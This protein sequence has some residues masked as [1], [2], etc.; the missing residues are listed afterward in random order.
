M[1]AAYDE[2]DVPVRGGFLHV[3]RW[4]TEPDLPTVVAVHGV[5]ANHRCWIALA[6]TGAVN[7]VAPDLRGRGR[8]G[9]LP[10]PA[11][12]AAHAEDLLTVLEHVGLERALLVGHS[13]G[14][15]VVTA[16]AAAHPDRTAGVLLVDGGLPL[17]APPPGVT[18]EQALAATIGP[19]AARLEMTFAD[20]AAY[21]D[22]WRPHPALRD[23][24]SADVEDYLGYDLV[25]E[26][27]HCRSSV[28]LEAV[29]DDSADLL[30][31]EANARRA[32][33]LPAGTVF[34]RAPAGLM[35]EPGGLYSPELT[36]EHAATYPQVSIRDVEDANHYTIVMSDVGARGLAAAIG[37]LSGCA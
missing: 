3:G 16:F 20:R 26:P 23:A 2:L 19:A 4:T 9:T 10:G 11:G 15:F 21:L 35:A 1:T 13:M 30:E 12:M 22:F 7:L 36:R 14:G 24:W 31:A 28:S 6:R 32:A 29:R 5:T 17:A 25:G 33:A 37:R 34:L 27:P 18:P 8:S